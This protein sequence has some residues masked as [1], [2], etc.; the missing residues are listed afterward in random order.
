MIRPVA[1]HRR[2]LDYLRGVAPLLQLEIREAGEEA[3]GESSGL[4]RIFP[5][6]AWG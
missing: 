1:N 3:R 6:Q 4:A 5:G 2:E